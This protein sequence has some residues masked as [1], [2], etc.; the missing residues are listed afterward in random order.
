V[1]L[2]ELVGVVVFLGMLLLLHLAARRLASAPVH[3]RVPLLPYAGVMVVVPLLRGG[4]QRPEFWG[5]A[6]IVVGAVVVAAG[7]S[8]ALRPAQPPRPYR[9][10]ARELSR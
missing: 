5:H 9:S 6:G 7:V 2:H 10:A 8:A 4:Y 3:V 1:L